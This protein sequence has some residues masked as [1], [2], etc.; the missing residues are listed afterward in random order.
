MDTQSVGL[1]SI[2]TEKPTANPDAVPPPAVRNPS[3]HGPSIDGESGTVPGRRLVHEGGEQ[4][5]A[6]SQCRR[7][8]AGKATPRIILPILVVVIAARLAIG[9]WSWVDLAIVSGILA[10]EPLTEWVIHVFVLHAKPR[11]VLGRPV[12]LHAA[13]KHRFHH[14][15]PTDPHTSFVPLADLLFLGAIAAAVQYT[16]IRS[17]GPFLSAVAV[18]LAMLLLYEWTH[19][20]IHTAY[21]PRGRYYR[22]IWRAHRLH[23]YKNEHYWYGVTVHLGDHLLRTFPNKSDVP[24]SATARTLGVDG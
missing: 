6:L 4:L 12:D 7:F 14:L 10:L 11:S 2:P 9:G 17:V 24:N 21:K 22:Y 5:K 20:L 3:Q 16:I 23:H 8:F 1:E 19:F 18:S 15:H 13:K